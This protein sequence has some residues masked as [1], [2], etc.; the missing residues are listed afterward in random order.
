MN[1]THFMITYI[2]VL[3]SGK[4]CKTKQK[5]QKPQEHHHTLTYAHAYKSTHPVRTVIVLPE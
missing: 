1:P 5:E 2:L 4:Q 3:F